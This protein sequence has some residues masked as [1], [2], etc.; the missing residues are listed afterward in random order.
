[1]VVTWW[2]VACLRS[3]YIVT[4][5]MHVAAVTSSDL[6][7]IMGIPPHEAASRAHFG[8]FRLLCLV[9]IY[10]L[11]MAMVAPIIFLAQWNECALRQNVPIVIAIAICYIYRWQFCK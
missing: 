10:S 9:S 5:T 7:Q 1:M 6:L 4:N 3:V 11:A 8:H 2:I